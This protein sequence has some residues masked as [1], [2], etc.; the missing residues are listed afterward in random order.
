MTWV[1]IDYDTF[2]VHL[3][4]V[5]E[6]DEARPTYHRLELEGEDAFT[7]LRQVSWEMPG[8][9]FWEDVVAAGIEEPGGKYVVGKLK[10]VQGAI[11]A[12]LPDDLLVQAY[13]AGLWRALCGLPGNSSKQEVMS[14][15][16]HRLDENPSWPQDAC[17]AYCLAIAVSRQ[18]TTKGTA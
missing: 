12:S 7:R 8:P 6:D 11:I 9:G 16:Y 5:P 17:D 3:V 15:V 10:G 18:V 13:Q 4:R 1:G 14:W 2:A